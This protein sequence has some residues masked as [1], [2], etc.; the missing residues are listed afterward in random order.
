MNLQGQCSKV[1]YTTKVQKKK[2]DSKITET[3]TSTNQKEERII[4]AQT[5][6][7]VEIHL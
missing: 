5:T 7:K 6:N 3:L 4:S 2:I 1:N